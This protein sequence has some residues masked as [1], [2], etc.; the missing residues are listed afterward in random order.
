MYIRSVLLFSFLGA[1]SCSNQEQIRIEGTNPGDCAD[2]ADNDADGKFDCKD[3]GCAGAPDCEQA[4][5]SSPTKESKEK[6]TQT[7]SVEK[8]SA[9]E[10]KSVSGSVE[11]ASFYTSLATDDCRAGEEGGDSSEWICKKVGSYT[12]VV[13]AI[14]GSDALDQ[15]S[16][17]NRSPLSS[18][19]LELHGGGSIDFMDDM[20]AYAVKGLK[21]IDVTAKKIEWRYTQN[22]EDPHALI[23]RVYTGKRSTLFVVRLNKKKTCLIGV[24]PKNKTARVIADNFELPCK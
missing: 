20:S 15:M 12:P 22:Q 13:L 19:R 4:K 9:N 3:E 2:G 1:V 23:F 18:L 8:T 7:E 17:D 21:R 10:K 6:K 24:T 16:I 11:G 14:G 5:N